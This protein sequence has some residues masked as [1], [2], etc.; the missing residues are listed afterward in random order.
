[1]KRHFQEKTMMAPKKRTTKPTRG[2]SSGGGNPRNGGRTSEEQHDDAMRVLN[3]EY[4]EGVRGL[5]QEVDR[6]IKD[7]GMDEG[8]A[9]HQV[10]DGSYWVIYTHAN[11]QVLMCS[12][13]HD[14][15]TEDF[16]DVPMQG[17][18]VNWAALAYAAMA[19][20]VSERLNAGDLEEAPRI[21]SRAA[22]RGR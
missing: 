16:G 22:R 19:Q 20:D 6:L 3:A 15:Y 5:A 7:E 17:R 1:V 13:N 10:V 21:G 2:G 14:A 4:Y 18:D 8:D 12:S 9:L 11:F